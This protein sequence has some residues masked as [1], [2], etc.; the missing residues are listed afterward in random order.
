MR[1]RAQQKYDAQIPQQKNGSA[2]IHAASTSQKNIYASESQ[3]YATASHVAQDSELLHEI[4]FDAAWLEQI[5]KRLQLEGDDR[6][7]SWLQQFIV[8]CQLLGQQHETLLENIQKNQRQE[9][10]LAKQHQALEL[11]QADYDKRFSGLMAKCTQQANK[12]RELNERELNAETGFSEQNTV[13][14]RSL[15][16]NQQQIG[17]QH[18]EDIQQLVVQKRELVREID[19][20][21][22]ELVQVQVQQ[23]E[24]EAQRSHVLDEREKE[25]TRLGEN[26]KRDCRRLERE[27]KELMIEKNLLNERLA[28]EMNMERAEFERKIHQLKR[29]FDSAQASVV[30][31]SERLAEREDLEHAL[32]GQPVLELL[33]ELETLRGENRRLRYQAEHTNLSEL[34]RENESL[35]KRKIDLES[36]LQLLRPEMDK[37]QREVGL[38]RVAATQLETTA[39]EKRVLEQQKNVLAHSIDELEVRIGRLTNANT[40]QTPF[41]AMSQMDAS[42]DLGVE[43]KHRDVGDLKTFA[44]ALQ[45]RIAQAEDGVQLFYPLDDIQLLLGG[46]SMS[47][48]HLFQG[49]SGTGKT[50]L[51]KAF[52]KSMGG[53]CTDISVQAGWRDRDDLL[54]HYNAFERRFYEKDCLQALY[55]AQIP[56][57]RDTCNV[58]LLD[59]MNLSRPEQYFAEFLSA[60][61]KNNP[62][63]RLITLSETALPNAPIKLVDGRQIWVPDNVW[64]IG[65]ANHDETTNELADKTYD[66]AHVMTLPK[67]DTRFCIKQLDKASYSWQSLREA[68][69]KAKE[70]H[71]ETVDSLLERLSNHAFTRLLEVDF[72]IGWGNRFNKQALDFIPVTIASGANNGRALDHLLATRVMRSGKVTGRYNISLDSLTQLKDALET[73]WLQANLA[74]EPTES[75]ALLDT[76]IRR[77]SGVR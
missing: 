35:L 47:Q 24:A 17:L 8:A 55:R 76:D 41:P 26:L 10:Q 49:I 59:E 2:A 20:A 75:L 12:E 39:L 1:K 66:R 42:R 64:F 68:F 54:G 21:R 48:L 62:A 29:Q 34:E 71:A 27:E 19:E 46:L 25:I 70:E 9:Q 45:Q 5:S 13:A 44:D 69:D 50:S 28:D 61:E 43:R 77:M 33:N 56:Y 14:L 57:W 15:L 11:E 63:E 51:A 67:R 38:H 22:K 36:E 30:N 4:D 23:S 53:F 60:L 37:L 73:F 7:V 40:T 3:I 52:A 18:Q 31:L 6:F 74:G 32:N 58:I 72:G 16:V 65:T